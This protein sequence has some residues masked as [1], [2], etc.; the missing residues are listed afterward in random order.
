MMKYYYQVLLCSV[1]IQKQF[2]TG[3]NIVNVNKE[4]ASQ[5]YDI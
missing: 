4:V 1:L 2:Q 5:F 3:T